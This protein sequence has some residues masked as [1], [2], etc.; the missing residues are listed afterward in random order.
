MRRLFWVSVGAGLG[1]SGYRRA[2]RVVR[3]LTGQRRPGQLSPARSAQLRPGQLRPAQQW[4]R[5]SQL[6]GVAGFVR[7]VRE[8]MD[9]YEEQRRPGPRAREV[10]SG[11]TLGWQPASGT[12]ASHNGASTH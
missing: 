12:G 1:I 10:P 8:G 6:R 11:P 2:S 9:L 7:D 3:E 5:L 4:P